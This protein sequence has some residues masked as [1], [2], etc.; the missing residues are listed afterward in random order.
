MNAKTK[1]QVKNMLADCFPLIYN[2]KDLYDE[3]EGM[4]LLIKDAND[5]II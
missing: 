2:K 4:F 1:I 5:I 3:S